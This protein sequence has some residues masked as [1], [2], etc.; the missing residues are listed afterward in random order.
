MRFLERYAVVVMADHGQTRVREAT[1]LAEVYAGVEGVLPL[2]SNRAAH[3]YLQP[4]CRLDAACGRGPPRR[5]RGRRG[6]AVSRGR[7]CRRAARRGGARLRADCR[8]ACSLSPAMPRSSTTPMRSR[9][10]WAALANPN[11]GEILVSAAEG[12]EFADLGGG[13]H[14]G[15]GS[16]GSLVTGDSEVP[17]L[18]RRRRGHG[19]RASSTSRRSSSPISV[20]RLPRMRWVAPPEPLPSPNVIEP[21]A[22]TSTPGHRAAGRQRARPAQQ[23]GA[24]REVLRRRRKRL[25]R[26]PRRLRAALQV[27]G[28]PL[29]PGRGRVVPRRRGEQLH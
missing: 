26:Q 10:A 24:A 25:R 4:G 6:D 23:L 12:Y 22:T 13:D 15:G 29:P 20:S 19:R 18:A 11:A 28:A 17:L 27:C 1:S 8:A 9:R 3:L 21:P 14:V 7:R 2:G 16:H 5:R